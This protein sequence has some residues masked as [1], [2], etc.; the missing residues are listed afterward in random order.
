MIDINLLYER[1][2]GVNCEIIEMLDLTNNRASKSSRVEFVVV[3]LKN[4]I[5]IRRTISIIQFRFYFHS[6]IK[7]QIDST[8][9][10]NVHSE[11]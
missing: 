1:E 8:T 7:I 10:R 11:K 3:K 4:T 5:K 6:I 9:T 2:R